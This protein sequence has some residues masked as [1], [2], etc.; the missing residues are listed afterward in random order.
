MPRNY[1]TLKDNLNTTCNGHQY[2]KLYTTAVLLWFL[3]MAK[4]KEQNNR[5][6]S[7]FSFSIKGYS[8]KGTEPSSWQIGTQSYMS[9][10]GR[11]LQIAIAS[12]H[13]W[14]PI[15]EVSPAHI[16]VH[17]KI[18]HKTD[19]INNVLFPKTGSESKDLV[20]IIYGW[21]KKRQK[22]RYQ[23]RSEYSNTQ[24]EVSETENTLI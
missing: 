17:V 23:A 18:I 13:L 7:Y 14:C 11:K 9:A 22:G 12:H 1:W 15:Q 2:L 4:C 5:V 19:F 21:Y 3:K 6:F 20:Q 24:R 8:D 16:S 10:V